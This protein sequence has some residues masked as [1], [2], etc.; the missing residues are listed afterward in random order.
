MN[1]V[2]RIFL[3]S[4]CLAGIGPGAASAAET[5]DVAKA[6]R[7]QVGDEAPL[8]EVTTLAGGRF[9]LQEQRGKVVLVSFFATWCG[10]CLQEM[11]QLEREAWQKYRGGKFAMIALGREHTNDDLLPF[12]KKQ[13]FTFPMAGDAKRAVYSRYAD[14]FIPRTVLIDPRGRVIAHVVGSDAEEFA[15]ILKLL[16]AELAKLK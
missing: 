8:F 7:V 16:A 13:A 9:S 15:G 12:Q 11:P 3:L 10:P 5:P 4:V 2:R 1:A 14:A 6:T